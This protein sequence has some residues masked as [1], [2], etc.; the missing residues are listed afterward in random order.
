VL[1]DL[2]LEQRR[3][4]DRESALATYRALLAGTP[5][6]HYAPDAHFALGEAFAARGAGDPTQWPQALAEYGE[7]LK[8]S[9][10][11]TVHGRAWYASGRIHL[12][13]GEADKARSE[14][15]KAIDYVKAFPQLRQGPNPDEMVREAA[16]LR[17]AD[18]AQ[19]RAGACPYRPS[20]D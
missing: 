18:P 2:A 6:S 13:A 7:V 20:T 8:L 12:C 10:P 4:P 9:G 14:L 5:I 11:D 15:Q 16:R 1:F 3:T 19:A 17:D